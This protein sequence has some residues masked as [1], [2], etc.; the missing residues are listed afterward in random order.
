M[1]NYNVFRLEALYQQNHQEDV[2]ELIQRAIIYNKS[3]SKSL[4]EQY[5]DLFDNEYDA[6]RTMLANYTTTDGL[7]KRPLAKLTKDI[8]EELGVF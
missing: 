6:R 5:T 2:R 7:E 1:L 3:F 8:C 4:F